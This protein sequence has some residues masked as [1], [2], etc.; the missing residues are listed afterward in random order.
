MTKFQLVSEDDMVGSCVYC[1][2]PL[3][4]WKSEFL[5]NTHYKTCSCEC[6][7]ESCVKVDFLGSGHDGWEES[8]IEEIV[9]GK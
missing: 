9:N 5:T 4:G 6:G 1:G 3:K 8:E 7:K 2:R